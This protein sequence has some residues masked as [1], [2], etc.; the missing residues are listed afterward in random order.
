MVRLSDEEPIKPARD[1]AANPAAL[2]PEA[3]APRSAPARS[4]PDSIPPIANRDPAGPGNGFVSRLNPRNWFRPKERTIVRYH[5]RSPAAPQ[6]GERGE[7][8][9]WLARGVA[10]QERNRLSESIEA[11]RQATIADP[12]FFE[13]HYNLGVAAY[14]AGECAQSL[15]AYEYAL[16]INPASVKARF[17][18]AVALQKANYPD[19]AANQLERLLADNPSEARA[20]LALANLYAQ[21]LGEAAKAR[22][23][24]LRLLELE[25]QHPQGTAIRYWF[26]ANP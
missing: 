11:Y 26:E 2:S 17:N 9:R 4:A 3:S 5:Y 13:A 20:H 7:G 12:S 22:E 16:A 6:P 23:H 24:Y 10:A 18:F 21:Q 15:L 14:E 8:E 25:P 19:D 1:I